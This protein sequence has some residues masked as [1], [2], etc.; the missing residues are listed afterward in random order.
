MTP[1]YRGFPD[2]ATK[3]WLPLCSTKAV[4]VRGEVTTEAHLVRCNDC[5]QILKLPR[6]PEFEDDSEKRYP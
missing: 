3:Q 2:F 4:P 5:R 6:L 1:H